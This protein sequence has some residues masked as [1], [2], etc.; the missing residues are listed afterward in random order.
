MD[1]LTAV[2]NFAEVAEKRNFSMVARG[3]YTSPSA[4]T[5]Q[6]NWLEDQVGQILLQRSTRNIELTV[7]GERFYQYAQNFLRETKLIKSQLQ[8]ESDVMSGRLAITAPKFFGEEKIASLIVKLAQQ[9]PKLNIEFNTTNRFIDLE[10]EGCDIAIRAALQVDERYHSVELTT[11][12]RGVFAS[13]DYL[14]QNGTP[15]HPRDLIHFN[16]VTHLD[17]AT[18]LLWSFKDEKHYPIKSKLICNSMKT[19]LEAAIQGLGLAHMADY[20]V[21]K[22]LKNGQLVQILQDYRPKP[23]PMVAVYRKM[24]L[25]P[26]KISTIIN[27]FKENLRHMN[28]E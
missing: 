25:V 16:C 12:R 18:S 11:A 9:Y 10:D 27:F 21:E 15:K 3:R 4:I 7:A 26:S 17:F 13:P 14:K 22:Y 19:Q 20:H 1:W 2:K 8:N 24:S 28:E 5:K 23:I 6:M